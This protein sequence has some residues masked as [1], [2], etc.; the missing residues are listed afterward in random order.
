MEQDDNTE[1][2]LLDDQ[3]GLITSKTLGDEK[4]CPKKK[5]VKK[6]GR[7]ECDLCGRIF[8][9]ARSLTTHL[10][11]HTK[12]Y[13]FVCEVLLKIIK[14]C[15]FFYNLISLFSFLCRFVVKSL[16]QKLELPNILV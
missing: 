10:L 11:L 4:E 7:F 15:D 9:F 13:R 5:Y 2:A 14:T 8:S 12:D 6:V 1:M 16:L 3:T